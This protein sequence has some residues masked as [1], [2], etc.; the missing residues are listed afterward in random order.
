MDAKELEQK[1]SHDQKKLEAD[2]KSGLAIER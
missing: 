2:A 1:K